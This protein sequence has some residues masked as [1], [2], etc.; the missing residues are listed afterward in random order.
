MTILISHYNEPRTPSFQKT[1]VKTRLSR[2][3]VFSQKT[4]ASHVACSQCSVKEGR[5]QQILRLNWRK[6]QK[7]NWVKL[8]K[9]FHRLPNSQLDSFLCLKWLQT[10]HRS[11]ILY[12]PPS[13][14]PFLKAT[15]APQPP[16]AVQLMEREGTK[17]TQRGLIDLE[18]NHLSLVALA[19]TDATEW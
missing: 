6:D 9:A 4:S 8:K 3:D 7:Q 11:S 17:G 5:K 16:V 13:F 12:V 2:K 19:G 1:K 10:K 14:C 15:R 18:G